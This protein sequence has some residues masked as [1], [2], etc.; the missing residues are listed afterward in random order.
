M[1]LAYPWGPKLIFMRLL[2]LW[3]TLKRLVARGS[4]RLIIGSSFWIKFCSLMRGLVNICWETWGNLLYL[5]LKLA[6]T[7][8]SFKEKVKKKNYFDLTENERRRKVGQKSTFHMHF[9]FPIWDQINRWSKWTLLIFAK[10]RV[11]R[12]FDSFSWAILLTV[13][14]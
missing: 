12:S 14:S 3:K 7:P 5:I 9:L 11:P 8:P 4:F 10:T 2:V 13:E 1:E 6:W